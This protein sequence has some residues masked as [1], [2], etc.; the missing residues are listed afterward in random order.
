MEIGIYEPP[1]RSPSPPPAP[2]RKYRS[3]IVT[4]AVFVVGFFVTLAV[5]G[6][7]EL[8]AMIAHRAVS[9]PAVAEAHFPAPPPTPHATSKQAPPA[10]SQAAAMPPSVFQ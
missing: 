5:L 9:R 8:A 1:P 2:Q 4:G 6:R 10:Q 3:A 7:H